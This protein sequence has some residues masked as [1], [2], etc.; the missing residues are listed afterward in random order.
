VGYGPTADMKSLT[1]MAQATG[2][3]AI[4]ATNPADLASAMAQA[5]L[6]AHLSR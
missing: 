3:Q 5:F 2:G 1:A 4:P 6:A